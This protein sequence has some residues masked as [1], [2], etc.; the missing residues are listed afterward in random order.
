MPKMK[1]L[2]VP[3]LLL[4]TALF[5]LTFNG[6]CFSMAAAP[7]EDLQSNTNT[8]TNNIERSSQNRLPRDLRF[9]SYFA[10]HLNRHRDHD[11]NHDCI[12]ISPNDEGLQQADC[13]M[14]VIEEEEE[15]EKAA[16]AAERAAP[17]GKDNISS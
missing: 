11:S 5:L 1:Q 12:K 15:E 13:S 17:Q 3:Y 9:F 14:G 6:G 7:T 8:N 4:I 10:S 2:F 16:V